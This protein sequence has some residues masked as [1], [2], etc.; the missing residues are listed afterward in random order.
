[1]QYKNKYKDSLSDSIK[2]LWIPF[3]IHVGIF[4]KQRT[5]ISHASKELFPRYL[6][7]HSYK[8]KC[9]FHTYFVD[10]KDAHMYVLSVIKCSDNLRRLTSISQHKYKSNSHGDATEWSLKTVYIYVYIHIYIYKYIM[11]VCMCQCSQKLE[12][13]RSLCS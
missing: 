6:T 5:T 3:Q 4:I 12:G 11:C 10:F 9:L 7:N 13:N 1:M 2:I 8:R